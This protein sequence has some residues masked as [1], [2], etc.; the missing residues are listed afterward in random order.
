MPC[1]LFRSCPQTLPDLYS[2]AARFADRVF[3]VEGGKHHTFGDVFGQAAQ[4]ASNLTQ[5]FAVQKGQRVA[6]A[7]QNSTGWI[8]AFLAVT[9]LGAVAV[10]VNSRGAPSELDR[11]IFPVDLLLGGVECVVGEHL[12]CRQVPPGFPDRVKVV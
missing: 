5:Q 2:Q 3:T 6:I 1:R 7:M 4:L 11:A 12:K 9:S 10:L 8:I